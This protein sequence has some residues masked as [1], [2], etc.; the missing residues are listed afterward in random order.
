[1]KTK[2]FLFLAVAASVAVATFLVSCN[3][4]TSAESSAT[5]SQQSVSLYLTDGAGAYDNVYLDIKS[6]ELLVDTSANTRV[7]DSCRWDTIGSKLTVKPPV[8][9]LVWDTLS[10]KAGVYDLLQLRNG[11]DTLL[12]TTTIPKGAV[13]LIRI[14]LGS[15]NSVVVDSVSYPLT[16]VP[17]FILVKLDGGEWQHFN[18]NHP[19]S[20]RLWL[21]FDVLHSIFKGAGKYFLSPVIKPFIPSTTGAITGNVAPKL[22]LPAT[23]TLINATA[24]DTSFGMPNPDGVFLFRGLKNG[25]YSL[26]VH[27]LRK[28]T[29]GVA[30]NPFKDTAINVT[31]SNANTVNVG[32][33]TLHN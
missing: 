26:L 24:A 7:H 10:F 29:L 15:N 13:R 22:A 19:N 32:T 16:N 1:M 31:V 11:V 5:A 9:A 17:S 23:L 6:I 3:K 2:H 20:Y 28:D 33:I 4:S 27:S 14:D 30:I 21:D 12:S 8:P 18:G 25:N